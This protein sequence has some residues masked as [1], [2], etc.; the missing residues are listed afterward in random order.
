MK[1]KFKQ[2]V[3]SETLTGILLIFATIISLI[4]A[5]SNLGQTY[6]HLFSEVELFGHFNIHM[7]VNDFFMAIFFLLVGLEIKHEILHGHL[8]SLKKA[9][10]PI[11]AALGGVLV[12]AII[13]TIFNHGTLFEHGIGVPI[14]TDIAFAIGIFMMLK[15]KMNPSLKIFLLSLAIVDDLISILLIG[16]LYSS[17]INFEFLSLASAIMLVLILMNKKFKVNKVTP[18][19]LIALVLWFCIYESGIH[20][21]ISGVLLALAI[22]TKVLKNEKESVSQKLE[23][24]LNPLCNLFIL[25]LFA[26]VNTAISLSIDIDLASSNTLIVGI[27]LGLVIGKPL[28]II[29]FTFIAAKLG[30]TEKPENATWV[31]IFSVSLLAGIG[32]TMAIFVAEIAFEATP[33]YISIAKISILG[34]SILSIIS[35]YIV[36]TISSRVSTHNMK[37][38][39]NTESE[40]VA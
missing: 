11:I 17:N 19:M 20:A 24:K 5:N 13:F 36:A 18:Y 2:I 9:T 25:P 22:P 15:S 6:H 27:V 21:T 23:H 3:K 40:S 1:S 12:P 10:F 34:A 37:I 31:S 30:I 4:I 14:S 28:G 38:S 32:F 39:N 29:L 33:E 8:S 7:I 16:I 35:T 26:L